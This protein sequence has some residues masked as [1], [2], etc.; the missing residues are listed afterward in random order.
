MNRN[1]VEIII[2]FGEGKL[3]ELD[4]VKDNVA[5]YVADRKKTKITVTSSLFNEETITLIE[6]IKMDSFKLIK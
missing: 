1:K 6:L 3:F 2:S 4:Y 5:H